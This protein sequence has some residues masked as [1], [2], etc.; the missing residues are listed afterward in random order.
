V[1]LRVGAAG[2]ACL[3]KYV[4]ATGALTASPVF[5]SSAQWGT[6]HIGDRSIIPSTT[7]TVQ[8]E[9]VPGTPMAS[10]TA[11]TWRW[12]D[13]DN[14]GDVNVFDIV[15][16]L[17]GLQGIFTN[18]TSYGVDQGAGTL[19]I[20]VTIDLADVTATLD[21][22][23]GVPYPDA[24]PCAGSFAA[25]MGSVDPAPPPLEAGGVRKGGLR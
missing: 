5:R 11:T 18:C 3:P 12:G 1:A 8:A 10:G 13:A 23:A 4:D 19:A 21:A 2:F 25:S 24:T 15:C 16:A 22:F 14:S 7:Y 6:V 20:P 9:V 17:D